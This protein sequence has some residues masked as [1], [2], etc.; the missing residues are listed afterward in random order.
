MG[1]G[2]KWWDIRWGCKRRWEEEDGAHH[3]V[4]LD[5]GSGARGTPPPPECFCLLISQIALLWVRKERTREVVD[6]THWLERSWSE[7]PR[8]RETNRQTNW[9]R[10]GHSEA[11]VKRDRPSLHEGPQLVQSGTARLLLYAPRGS[12]VR[13]T[14]SLDT[15]IPRQSVRYLFDSRVSSWSSLAIWSMGTRCTGLICC[16]T[17]NI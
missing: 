2:G 9:A 3:K 10:W 7:R 1:G 4:K 17:Q 16:V 13:E 12:W 6:E 11:E 15:L 14:G 8:D 5:G